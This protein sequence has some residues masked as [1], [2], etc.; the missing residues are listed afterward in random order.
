[1]HDKDRAVDASPPPQSLLATVMTAVASYAVKRGVALER[2]AE[3]AGLTPHE[4]IATPERVPEDVI[5]RI[6]GLLQR[7]FPDEPVAL[8]VAHAA[9]MNV[10][11]PL[12]QAARLVPDL[13]AGID[14]FVR[15]SN[16]VSTSSVIRF[17]SAPPGP[18]IRLEHANDRVEGSLS[19]EMALAMA[20]RAIAE[21]LGLPQALREVWLAH[22][23]T[24]AEE[25]YANAFPARVRLN[26]PCNGLLFHAEHLGAPVDPSAGARLRVLHAHLE[27]VQ[28]QL[29]QEQDP[30]EL[31]RIRDA[32]TRNAAVGEFGAPALARRLGVSLRTLQRRVVALGTNVRTVVDDVRAATARQLLSDPM[33]SLYDVAD[34]LGYSTESAFRRA[35]RRWT[36]QSPGAYRRSLTRPS[37]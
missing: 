30:P 28:Q 10:F 32:A 23:P 9:S 1:M 7:H 22:A 2:V 3:A 31:R 16:V 15:F 25:H 19:T 29:A 37:S 4:L 12:E 8:R 11:G 14:I 20:A 36:G 18:M 34:A 21:V 5:P 6:L 24:T 35:F 27:L 26:A 33:L 13:R 17:V